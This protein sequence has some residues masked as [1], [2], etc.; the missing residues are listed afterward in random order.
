MNL[1]HNV[2]VISFLLLICLFIT[3]CGS[4][5]H[6]QFPDVSHPVED[7]STLEEDGSYLANGYSTTGTGQ[8]VDEIV[9][10]IKPEKPA[11]LGIANLGEY[12]GLHLTFTPKTVSEADVQAYL[13]DYVLPA[14][15]KLKNP[16]DT[17]TPVILDD[18]A[19]H[20]I[21]PSFSSLADYKYHVQQLLIKEAEY[22]NKI[23]LYYTA[24]DAVIQNSNPI[25]SEE[26]IEWQIDYYLKA[27]YEEVSAFYDGMTL[28][29]IVTLYGTT[30]QDFRNSLYDFA[31]ESVNQLLI[32][33]AI[34]DQENIDV[35]DKD[36]QDYAELHGLTVELLKDVSTKEDLLSSVRRELAAQFVVDHSTIS[37]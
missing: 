2:N 37:K 20:E 4:N 34:A 29:N 33:D 36:I 18:Y 16:S 23:Q 35:T 7:S 26:A 19:I 22:T 28:D 11:N 12:K 31:V 8:T 1:K 17:D 25:P 15:K 27:Y 9:A 6:P 30:Y 21:D 32:M 24:I 3:A 13:D 14:Y 10:E 5:D